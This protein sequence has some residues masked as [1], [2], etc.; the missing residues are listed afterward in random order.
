MLMRKDLALA[1]NTEQLQK[2][3]NY[4]RAFDKLPIQRILEAENNKLPP[5]RRSFRIEQ[6]LKLEFKTFVY[7]HCK[8]G[9][10]SLTIAC[11]CP[12]DEKGGFFDH[13]SAL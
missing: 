6:R 11:F 8:P 10:A 4:N 13:V 7:K 1:D 2:L 3:Y 5:R 9:Y 12:F